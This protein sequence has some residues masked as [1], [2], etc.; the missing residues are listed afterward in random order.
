MR[1]K[2]FGP[3][4]VLPDDAPAGAIGAGLWRELLAEALQREQ[5]AEA[6]QSADCA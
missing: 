3:L 5:I 4:V 2:H 1:S 6:W